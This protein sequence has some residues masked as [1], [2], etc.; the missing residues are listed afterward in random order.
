MILSDLLKLKE[1]GNPFLADKEIKEKEGCLII[2]GD[3]AFQIT[4]SLS[5]DKTTDI[6]IKLSNGTVIGKLKFLKGKETADIFSLSDEEYVC[7]LREYNKSSIVDSSYKFSSDFL[8]INENHLSDY[9]AKYKLGSPI[10]GSFFHIEDQ[11]VI[12]FSQKASVTSIEA[13]EGIEMDNPIYRENLF[14]SISE[15]NPINRF[16]KLYHLLELQFDL[17]TAILIK[18][19]LGQGGKEKEISSKLRD[20]TRDED[21]RL[22][23]LVK[24]K[25]KNLTRLVS[26][27]N[28]VANFV[29]Q[30]I[31]IFYEY[32]RTKNPLKRTDFNNLIITPNKFS[33]VSVESIG[34][35][36]FESLIPKL[37]SYWIYRVRSCVAHNRFGEYIL[38]VNDEKFIVEFA[39]PLLK[40]VITQCF[41]S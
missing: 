8:L 13:L 30:A 18:D 7:F 9:L 28:Q 26:C 41:K 29:A 1:D 5:Y 37:A 3:V 2:N 4:T 20:Y 34:G 38:R 24:E 35:Y 22:D 33:K 16:L 31:T 12:E 21:E 40:E 39:E 19:L 25:C 36:S 23:S 10:W 17:H 15:P 14:L 11:P 6:A 27:L 32:G